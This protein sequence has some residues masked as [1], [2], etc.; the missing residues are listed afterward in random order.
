MFL[1]QVLTCKYYNLIEAFMIEVLLLILNCNH[2]KKTQI[3]ISTLNKKIII[4]YIYFT[5]IRVS[6]A[7]FPFPVW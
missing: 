2:T 1:N 6:G 5:Q 3:S 4:L 7:I